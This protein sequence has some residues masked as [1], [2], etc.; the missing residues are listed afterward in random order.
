V[1]SS[2]LTIAKTMNI[3]TIKI[4]SE[5]VDDIAYE[6]YITHAKKIYNDD[7]YRNKQYWSLLSEHKI[8]EYHTSN[9]T[10]WF[11]W[12]GKD[13][14][15]VHPDSVPVIEYIHEKATRRPTDWL[16]EYTELLMEHPQWGML[17]KLHEKD[18]DN[19]DKIK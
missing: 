10:L 5:K 1:G 12:S 4:I 6:R 17:P 3:Q 11:V 9:N 14:Y 8:S 7:K 2:I 16:K 19:N 13:T 18:F 15:L